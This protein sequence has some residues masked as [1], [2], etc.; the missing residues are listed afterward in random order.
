MATSLSDTP[1]VNVV[2]ETLNAW[3]RKVPDPLKGAPPGAG[4]GALVDVAA[5]V[6]VDAGAAPVDVGA[7]VAM[8]AAVVAVDEG[9]VVPAA[10]AA[11]AAVVA[12]A[13][14]VCGAG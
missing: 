6:A 3:L 5:V 10:V 14:P 1:V 2:Q 9:A 12:G 4:I 8:V 7:V 11:A 13:V